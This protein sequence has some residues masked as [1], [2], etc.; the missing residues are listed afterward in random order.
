MYKILQYNT[1]LPN[2]SSDM[3]HI[4]VGSNYNNETFIYIKYIPLVHTL[5]TEFRL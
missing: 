1:N 3:A 2:T 5:S 4:W